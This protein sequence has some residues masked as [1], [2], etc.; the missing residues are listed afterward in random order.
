MLHLIPGLLTSPSSG[1]SP[2]RDYAD[3][4][5][6]GFVPF[7]ALLPLLPALCAYFGA[8]NVGWDLFGSAQ[9]RRLSSASA[10]SLALMLYLTYVTSVLVMGLAVRWVLYRTPQRPAYS[11][12][13]T[14]TAVLAAP[15]AL[16]GIVTVFPLR[17][18][19]LPALALGALCTVL[20]LYRGLPAYLHLKR[21][22][23]E[24]FYATCILAAGILVVLTLAFFFME[25]WWQPLDG[26]GYVAPVE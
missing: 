11:V 12:A 3:R 10:A 1:W 23:Q 20:L 2:I 9:E 24:R 15:L 6:W 26:G 7:L 18:L 8:T 25:L 14:F 13:T 5:P 4:H 16:A 21:N 17:W 22:D 19:L